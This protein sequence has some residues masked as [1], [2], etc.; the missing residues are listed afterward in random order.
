MGSKEMVTSFCFLGATI[1]KEG[2]CE[3]DFL[4]LNDTAKSNAQH[5]QWQRKLGPM[6]KN[7]EEQ[8]CEQTDKTKNYKGNGPPVVLQ[9]APMAVKH[10]PK[11]G[12]QKRRLMP[13]KCDQ[14][15][16]DECNVDRTENERVDT[17]GARGNDRRLAIT[18]ESRKTEDVAYIGNLEIGPDS[19]ELLLTPLGKPSLICRSAHE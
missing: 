13:V 6:E 4:S 16:E 14:E 11:Q 15:E 5:A 1:E 3:K 12:Q 18:T 10:G 9:Q 19:P 8:T 17:A 7:M 2:G